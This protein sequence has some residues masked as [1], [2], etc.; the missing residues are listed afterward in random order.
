[1]AISLAASLFLRVVVG[2]NCLICWMSILM[3]T[4]R[5]G[6]CALSID[7]LL[8]AVLCQYEN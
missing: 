7:G 8:S 1:M 6:Q 2:A 5:L 4:A 3:P